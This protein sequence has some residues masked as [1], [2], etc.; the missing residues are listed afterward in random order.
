[1]AAFQT[2]RQC[3]V[4]DV[5]GLNHFMYNLSSRNMLDVT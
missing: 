3:I 4:G 5:V 2:L 1:M